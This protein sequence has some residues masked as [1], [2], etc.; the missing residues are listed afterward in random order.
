MIMKRALRWL[1][2]EHAWC[3]WEPQLVTANRRQKHRSFVFKKHLHCGRLALWA[4]F[5]SGPVISSFLECTKGAQR[6]E[7]KLPCLENQMSQ[8]FQ[9]LKVY[10]VSSLL[11]MPQYL[12]TFHEK[13]NPRN[14]DM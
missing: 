8:D 6:Q 4:L 7:I 2:S 13:I 10:F 5:D 3:L 11:H 12:Y 1:Y 14:D 9:E